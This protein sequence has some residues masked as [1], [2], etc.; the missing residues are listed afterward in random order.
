MRNC[1]ARV[2]YSRGLVCTRDALTRI[3]FPFPVLCCVRKH[4][5][6]FNVPWLIVAYNPYDEL[7]WVTDGEQ[8]WVPHD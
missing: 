4:P 7:L 5:I 6:V 1:V 8:L 2:D 3:Y